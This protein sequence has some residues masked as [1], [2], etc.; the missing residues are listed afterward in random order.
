M[1][2][3]TEYM[4]GGDLYDVLGHDLDRSFSWHGRWDQGLDFYD[5]STKTPGLSVA[6]GRDR[7]LKCV[8]VPVQ[9]P[10]GRAG[11]CAGHRAHARP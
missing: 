4:R 2:L 7:G 8:S 11:H 5:C 6:A 10:A 3:V 9:G 1:V